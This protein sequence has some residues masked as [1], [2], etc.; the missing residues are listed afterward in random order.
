MSRLGRASIA[1]VL[2]VAFAA[3]PLAADWC[4]ASC[5]ATDASGTTPDAPVCHHAE[6]PLVGTTVGINGAMSAGISKAPKTCGHD[7]RSLV[8]VT[9]TTSSVASKAS[10]VN[11]TP[12]TVNPIS[13]VRLAAMTGRTGPRTGSSSSSIPLALSSALRI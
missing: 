13:A 4:A 11:P 8:V 2:L 12:L 7:H 1:T 3:V 6:S 10:M 9:A 5:E